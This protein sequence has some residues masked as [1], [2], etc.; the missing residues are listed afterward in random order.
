[1]GLMFANFRSFEAGPDAFG[2]TWRVEFLWHQ[3]GIAIRH[4]DT[5][6]VKFALWCGQ[7]RLEKVIALRHADLLELSRQAGRPV[8]DPWSIRLAALHLKH[9]IETGE[10]VEKTLVTPPLAALEAHAGEL[11]R[12]ERR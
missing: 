3:N 8:T 10:D 4:S 2:Q 6:D 11:G 12:A 9:M 5:V 7:T 1:M